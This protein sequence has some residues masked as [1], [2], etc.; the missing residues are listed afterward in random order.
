MSAWAGKT[1]LPCPL[2]TSWGEGTWNCSRVARYFV[3]R[4]GLELLSR[5]SIPVA[6][7]TG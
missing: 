2:P 3:G 6:R 5:G 4:G 1:P 7:A